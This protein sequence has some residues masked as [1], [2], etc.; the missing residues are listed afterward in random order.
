[1]RKLIKGVTKTYLYATSAYFTF[2]SIQ[3]IISTYKEYEWTKENKKYID[4][5]NGLAKVLKDAGYFNKE[6]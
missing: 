6:V 5:I 3:L 2:I 4:D 1:M